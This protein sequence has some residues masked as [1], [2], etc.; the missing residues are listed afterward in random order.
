MQCEGCE[1]L[2]QSSQRQPLR[3]DIFAMTGSSPVLW[4]SMSRSMIFLPEVFLNADLLIVDDGNLVRSESR[5]L[6]GKLHREGR[7]AGPNEDSTAL[8]ARRVDGELGDL[9]VG[10]HPG[11]QNPNQIALV[12]PFRSC[13]SGFGFGLSRPTDSPESRSRTIPACV[14]FVT[15]LVV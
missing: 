12:N 4:R 14:S 6:L 11:R 8:V 9:V 15:G 10:R 2:V 3:A 7:I 5:R 13:H 1:L